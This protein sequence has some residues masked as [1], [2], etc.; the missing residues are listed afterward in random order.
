[1]IDRSP[2]ERD[3]RSQDAESLHGLLTPTEEEA[4]AGIQGLHVEQEHLSED[5][6]RKRNRTRRNVLISA[7]AVFAVAL[8]MVGS[9]IGPRLGLFENKDYAGDGNGTSVE[10]TVAQGDS[11][12]T[13][14]TKLEQK[15]V[16]ADARHFV[17]VFEKNADGQFIQPGT[18][19]LE[20]K[21]SSRAALDTLLGEAT[22]Y[23]AIAQG[24]RKGETFQD[25]AEATGIN[26]AKFKA[27]DEN[28]EQFGIPSQF[29]SLE[30]WLHPGEY[31]FPLDVTAEEVIQKLVE[32]TRKDLQDL[33]VTGDQE[34]FRVLT[35]ASILELEAKPE[36]YRAVAGAIENRISEPDGETNGYIQSDATVTYGLDKKTYQITP[37]EKADASNPYNTFVHKGLPAGPIDS[38]TKKAMAAAA[39]PEENDYFYWVTVNLKTGETK[40][41]ETYAEHQKNVEQYQQ[42][43]AEHEGQCQ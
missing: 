31:R 3:V 7:A 4:R 6:R 1:M 25:L 23:V 27:L 32:A 42:W 17:K 35:I 12:M 19:E 43:C 30:G 9:I 33:G 24:Q 21:M 20:K 39:D 40:F 22:H 10:V 36:D 8:I 18:F 14:A 16:I 41:A 15:G 37:E 5:Q 28:P 2:R 26:I 29:P 11:N 34:V 13:V 38:P